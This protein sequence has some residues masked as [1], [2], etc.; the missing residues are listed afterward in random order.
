MIGLEGGLPPS[1][2][3][4]NLALKGEIGRALISARLP[5]LTVHRLPT[6]ISND[7]RTHPL[8]DLPP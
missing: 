1:G 4:A 2:L 3:P 5:S 6:E 8:V 7:G